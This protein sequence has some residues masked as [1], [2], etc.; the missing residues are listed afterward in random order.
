MA[1][2]LRKGSKVWIDIGVKEK[3]PGIIIKKFSARKGELDV[4]S[5][6][7]TV[8]SVRARGSIFSKRPS[9]LK[10]RK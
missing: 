7:R 3:A 9:E 5:N 10:R 6:K 1:K 4:S 8:V 2:N